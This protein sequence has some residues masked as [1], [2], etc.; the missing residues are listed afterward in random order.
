MHRIHRAI[1]GSV[2]AAV[3]A[4][5]LIALSGPPAGAQATPDVFTETTG[6]EVAVN[7]TYLPIVGDFVG[8]SDLDDI[9][10]YAPGSGR[11]SLWLGSSVPEAPFDRASVPQLNGTY[12]P[13]VGDFTGDDLDDIIWYGRGTAPDLMWR[14]SF[15]GFQAVQVSINGTFEPI[16]L[17]N[18]GSPDSVFWYA[19]GSA[20]DW[21]WTFALGGARSSAPYQVNGSFKPFSGDFD[22]NRLGDIF[23]YAPG[24]APDARWMRK[25]T[26]TAASFTSTPESV[27]G[28]YAPVVGQF[29]EPAGAY[30]RIEEDIVWT[31]PTGQDWL[32]E[33]APTGWLK[34]PID[35]GGQRAIRL[36]DQF[37][38]GVV[39]VNGGGAD[40][41][42]RGSTIGGG[43][44]ERIDQ[45]PIPADA[46]P[47]VGRFADNTQHA[48]LWYRPGAG[49]ER[50]WTFYES[51]P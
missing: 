41:L 37:G 49:A 17:S 42:W 4:T 18:V 45:V 25:S 12:T 31:T 46:R 29:L 35:L 26:A 39:T 20:T 32:W 5:A 33:T 6:T 28:T 24:T 14:A 30:S 21:L 27:T 34:R 44:N 3:V 11:E 22:G 15:S 23:W 51:G 47:I 8:N 13:V 36:L 19:P 38:D 2:V 50:L 10:W 9:L 48:V 43:T 1:S 7:G 16:V 40:R